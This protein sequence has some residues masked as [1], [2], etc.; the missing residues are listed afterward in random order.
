MGGQ[1]KKKQT[2]SKNN[3]RK[4]NATKPSKPIELPANKIVT[5]LPCESEVINPILE[6]PKTEVVTL[7]DSGI[8]SVKDE[9]STTSSANSVINEENPKISHEKSEPLP[10]KTPE[11]EKEEEP[12]EDLSKTLVPNIEQETEEGE[13]VEDTFT[14]LDEP[15]KFCMNHRPSA[16]I[17]KDSSIS[18]NIR[19][20]SL[21]PEMDEKIYD[22]CDFASVEGFWQA[23]GHLQLPANL[24]HKTR[25]NVY[26]F[27]KSSHPIW[28]H[29]TNI[30]GCQWVLVIPRDKREYLNVLWAELCLAV[31]GNTFPEECADL[32]NGIAAQKRQKEDRLVLWAKNF[33]K[34]ELQMKIGKHLKEKVWNL[35]KNTHLCCNKF[36]DKPKQVL[37]NSSFQYRSSNADTY[38]V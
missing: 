36:D 16:N 8:E 17:K 38:V 11:P 37:K 7:D 31:V 4:S 26:L 32:I 3:R 35:N 28:E 15:W 33:S 6:S 14:A 27:K 22:I 12:T 24:N 34:K 13:I 23:F 20:M 21:S 18:G 19:R 1:Q 5:E 25:P 9:S 2:K 30:G 29:H 10:I